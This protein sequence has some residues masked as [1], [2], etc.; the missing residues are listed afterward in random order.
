[1]R[2]NHLM[3]KKLR[4]DMGLTQGQM[5]DRSGIT[6]NQIAKHE[7]DP[8]FNIGLVTLYQYAT[9]F[10]VDL[11][12]LFEFDGNEKIFSHIREIREKLTELEMKIKALESEN[13]RLE[14]TVEVWKAAH[15]QLLKELSKH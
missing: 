7:T 12:E 6:R 13:I 11:S 10:N 15:N 5:S 14:A 2:F 4:E 3:L 1:M 8:D 9:F